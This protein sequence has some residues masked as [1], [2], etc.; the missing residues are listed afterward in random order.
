MDRLTSRTS[1]FTRVT[2][3]TVIPVPENTT[4][5]GVQVPLTK[6]KP[7]TLMVSLIGPA[8]HLGGQR[9]QAVRA[10]VDVQAAV[11]VAPASP[12][13]VTVTLRL[14]I[15]APLV[16]ETS[17]VRWVASTKVVEAVTPVP[18]I[19]TVLPATKPVPTMDTGKLM[20]PRPTEA[21]ATLVTVATGSMTA[22]V[23][24][25]D[26]LRVVNRIRERDRAGR[27]AQGS[28]VSSR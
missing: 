20:A 4:E 2:E 17:A 19:A 7:T 22:R 24:G 12:G 18:E 6:L 25:A 3:C 27:G 5:D 14:P 28:S 15:A 9:G 21:G 26:E 11:Q 8:A 1:E 13:F 23:P 16:T 10:L